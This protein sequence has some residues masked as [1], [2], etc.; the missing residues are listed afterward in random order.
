MPEI[1]VV[2]SEESGASA[3]L[4]DL[5]A[6]GVLTRACW[7]GRPELERRLFGVRPDSVVI[8]LDGRLKRDASLLSALVER[9][10]ALALPA[11]GVRPDTEEAEPLDLLV[12]LD[13]VVLPPVRAD[14]VLLRLRIAAA[15]RGIDPSR[16]LA[17]GA[18]T[19]DAEGFRAY[20]RGE[21]LDL[22]YKEFELLRFLMVNQGRVVTRQA[23]L[24][25]VWGYDFYGGLRTVDAHIRRLR[26]KIE[27]RAPGTIETI[28][29]V[30]YR[31]P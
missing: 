4:D 28:R 27:A 23:I 7:H 13:D 26:S 10:S 15:R 25:H 2:A 20:V 30:G 31:I 14:E 29:N 12:K 5:Q 17:A 6:A 24:D 19:L 1:A 21:P 16:M 22:T 3:F 18:L 11:V 9:L 8:W